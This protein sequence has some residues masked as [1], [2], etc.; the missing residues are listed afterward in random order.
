MRWPPGKEKAVD[1][2]M[3]IFDFLGHEREL[4]VQELPQ[5][6]GE[7]VHYYR[8]TPSHCG[9]KVIRDEKIMIES[10]SETAKP[11]WISARLRRP[12]RITEVM[13]RPA[14]RTHLYIGA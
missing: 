11:G 14:G 8:T 13:F 6:V 1:G 2:Q 3:S 7:S 5:H 9:A 10:A 12:D 4:Q